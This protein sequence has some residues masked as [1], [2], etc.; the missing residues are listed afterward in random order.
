MQIKAETDAEHG[1]L[2][3]PMP[4]EVSMQARVRLP[5]Q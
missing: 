4:H 5:K 3:E 1:A 2:P